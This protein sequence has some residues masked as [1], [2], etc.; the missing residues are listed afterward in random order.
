[1]NDKYKVGIKFNKELLH[2]LRSDENSGVELKRSQ[3]HL[4]LH[5]IQLNNFSKSLKQVLNQSIA[6]YNRD[7]DGILLGFEKTKLLSKEGYIHD[8]SCY[9]H[10]D[11]E[12]D[13]YV[14]TPE[15]GKEMKG[16]VNRKS[17]DHV[18]LLVYNALNVSILKP[19]DNEDWIGGFVELGAEVLFR[20]T[21]ISLTSFMPYIRGE[22]ISILTDVNPLS[23]PE[24]KTQKS[25]KRKKDTLTEGTL[26][27]KRRKVDHSVNDELEQ[28]LIKKKHS[29]NF[30]SDL[31]QSLSD[32]VNNNSSKKKTKQ[33]EDSSSL[34]N[35]TGYTTFEENLLESMDSPEETPVKEKKAK[36]DKT[37]KKDS[38]TESTVIPS[39]TERSKRF[40]SIES[41]MLR[42]VE[43]DSLTL[44]LDNAETSTILEL[45]GLTEK[46]KTKAK[47]SKL[48]NNGLVENNSSLAPNIHDAHIEQKVDEGNIKTRKAKGKRLNSS[49]ETCTFNIPIMIKQESGNREEQSE[50]S[51][52]GNTIDIP[53]KKKSKKHKD[54]NREADD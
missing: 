41:P 25:K 31:D 29:K 13:F 12:A 3:Y 49:I 14:F 30:I 7:L 43:N 16:I 40:S 11:I 15:I 19:K 4:S 39:I 6:K 17:K 5:P 53:V 23:E 52:L 38:Y 44:S 35:S 32:L 45:G 36:K 18:G 54:N 22:I 37:N 48:K 50:N 2:S 1:M 34:Q 46:A 47:K 21:Y 33:H 27:S 51:T 9:I 42:P 8:D 26:N 24:D 20:I 28:K 10:L